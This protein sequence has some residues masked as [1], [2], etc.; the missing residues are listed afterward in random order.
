[1][2]ATIPL[3][4]SL[5]SSVQK[6]DHWHMFKQTLRPTHESCTTLDKYLSYFHFSHDK[7]EFKTGMKVCDFS[8]EGERDNAKRMCTLNTEVSLL[9]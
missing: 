9:P 4:Q 5:L 1:M 6:I 7:K 3:P 8:V 2:L